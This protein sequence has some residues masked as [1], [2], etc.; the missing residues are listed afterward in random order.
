MPVGRYSL[1]V[2]AE[3]FARNIGRQE[4]SLEVVP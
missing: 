4:V 2:T 3:D 1:A